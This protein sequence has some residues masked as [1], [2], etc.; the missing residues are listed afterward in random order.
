MGSVGSGKGHPAADHVP[1]GGQFQP[2]IGALRAVRSQQM[3]MKS[4]R[5]STMR[6]HGA[7]VE[8]LMALWPLR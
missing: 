2:A 5:R 8:I 3:P 4:P 6:P 7:F 1:H